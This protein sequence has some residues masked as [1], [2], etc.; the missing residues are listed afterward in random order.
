MTVRLRYIILLVAMHFG[1]WA[2]SGV[3]HE[4]YRPQVHFSPPAHWMNDPNGMVYYGG[5]YHLFYQYYPGG[6]V[7]GPMHWGH[8][9]SSDLVHWTNRPIALYPDSLG[10]IFSGSAVVDFKNTSGL[11][12]NGQA[13]L[14]A[15]FT[16]HSQAREKA[17][18]SDAQNQSL[19]Y[20]NDGGTS[21]KMYE[22]N[23]VLKNPGITDFRDPNVMWY[24]PDQKWIMSLATKDRITFYSSKNLNNWTKESEFG[25]H[26]GAHGGVWECPDLFPLKAADGK[27]LWILLVNINPGGPQGGSATQYFT[28]SFDGKKFTPEG[29][30]TR[31]LDQGTDEY[32]GVTWHNTGSRRIFLGWMSNWDYATSVPTR[33]WRS[34]MTVPRELMLVKADSGYMV[35]AEPVKELTRLEGIPVTLKNV[36]F[37]D[38]VDL[39]RKLKTE[40]APYKL[41]LNCED[42]TGFSIKLSNQVG[43][44]LAIGYDKKENAWFIDRTKA[45]ISD[46][47]KHFAKRIAARRIASEKS[48]ELTL[49]V[50]AASVELFADGGLNVM[51]AIYFPHKPFNRITISSPEQIRMKSIVYTP[52]RGIWK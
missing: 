35:A 10:L 23:P 15:I 28:G 37:K 40:L 52:L 43:E 2:Q 12:K 46:F 50:D 42:L 7:W 36:A 49:I 13:P 9:T 27:T 16:Q 48:A 1:A 5:V 19:A 17:G 44:E 24:A 6:T 21:W 34:A 14:V 31:W 38:T 4:P 3:Y 32:A 45:G 33:T 22:H 41:R 29:S 39:T 25:E 20:S 8:A 51:T 26:Q 47:N 11:G 18:R 30:N